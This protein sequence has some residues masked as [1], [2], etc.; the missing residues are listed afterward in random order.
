M[1]ALG[2]ASGVMNK[3]NSEMN[4]ADIQTMMRQFEKEQMK[5]GMK[6]EMIGEAMDMGAEQTEE[7]DDV[8]QQICDEVG[9]NFNDGAAVGNKAL[10]V[11]QQ[12]V[13][14]EESKNELDDLEA[15]LQA[16]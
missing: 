3:A 6:Q 1:Q 8:Y 11:Q 7:A 9:I 15:R 10:P 14:Q 2:N 4:I 13:A 12:A 16:L 5:M